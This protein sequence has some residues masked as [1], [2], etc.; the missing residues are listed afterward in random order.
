MAS[1]AGA[2]TTPGYKNAQDAEE[3]PGVLDA[4]TVAEKTL[5]ALGKGPTTVPG[6]VNKMARFFM[7]RLLPRKMAISIMDKNTK[8]LS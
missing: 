6:K 7:S 8:G 4:N 3:A 1:C 5:N 2:I